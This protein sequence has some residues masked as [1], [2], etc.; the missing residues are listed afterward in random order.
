MS[1]NSLELGHGLHSTKTIGVTGREF[2]LGNPGSHFRSVSERTP[3]GRCVRCGAGM[4]AHTLDS[5]SSCGFAFDISLKYTCVWSQHLFAH[6]HPSFH[7]DYKVGHINSVLFSH[8]TRLRF[9]RCQPLRKMSSR[10]LRTC[11]SNNMMKNTNY[12]YQ[13]H[14]ANIAVIIITAE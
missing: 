8:M 11:F 2:S 10:Y 4:H 13:S 1:I 12:S 6:A 9:P 5:N 7:V 14:T 3:S